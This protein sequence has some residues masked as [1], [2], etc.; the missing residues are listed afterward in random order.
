GKLFSL[1]VDGD[2]YTQSLYLPHVQI[3]G[4]G[5][6]NVVFVATEHDSVYAFD[7]EGNPPSPLWRVS[8]INPQNG[9]T[10]IPAS[11]V[12]C[13]FINPEVGITPTPVIDV[14]TGTIYVLARTK[15]R[16]EYVQ[17]LHALDVTSG[18]EKFGGPVV[19]GAPVNNSAGPKEFDAR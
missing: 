11:D 7:A 17:R 14:A 13:P 9:V 3:A 10:T 2:I 12:S 1:K 16:K 6:H 19:I 18:A 8:F 15:E 5:R 4:K